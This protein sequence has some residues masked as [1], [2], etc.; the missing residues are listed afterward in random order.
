MKV[1]I[2]GANGQLGADLRR[3]LA[4]QKIAAVPLTHAT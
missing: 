2:V 3:V 4:A 1:V